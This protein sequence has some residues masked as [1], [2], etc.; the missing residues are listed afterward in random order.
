MAD[1]SDDLIN[2]N[3]SGRVL[4]ACR[5]KGVP[6]PKCV[7]IYTRAV[8]EAVDKLLEGKPVTIGSIESVLTS[9]TALLEES[10][11]TLPERLEEKPSVVFD[12]DVEIP[13]QFVEEETEPAEEIEEVKE[14]K[15][16]P[17]EES[18]KK[19]EPVTMEEKLKQERKPLRKLIS[20]DCVTLGL[21]TKDRAKKML[22]EMTGRMPEEAEELVIGELRNNLHDQVRKFMRK[23]K[24]GP[25]N[26]PMV[27][28]ELRL[29][30]VS[31]RSVITLLTLTRQ[32][33]RERE[34]WEAENKKGL[35]HSLVGGK[36]KMSFGKK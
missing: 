28:E 14:E 8:R 10:L 12:P 13:E 19:P 2:I 29:D 30:I 22:V 33:L 17:K 32:I 27:Q 24:G 11:R 9:Q 3:V 36:V 31:T 21:V 35:L 16:R 5:G 34:K 26:T 18:K 1:V 7:A 25:W 4:V 6:T 15:K 23:N 20:E